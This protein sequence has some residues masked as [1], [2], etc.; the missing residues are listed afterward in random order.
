VLI[1][2]LYPW[3][4][5]KKVSD[6]PIPSPGARKSLVSDIPAGEGKSITFFT[7]FS[8]FSP[9]V[10]VMGQEGL[11]MPQEVKRYGT[12]RYT[13]LRT[14]LKDVPGDAWGGLIKLCLKIRMG[15][16]E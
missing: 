2:K 12:S 1:E 15:I 9:N 14:E 13:V 5:V 4:T 8:Y 11:E 7:K 16:G 6:F 3:Y 10:V